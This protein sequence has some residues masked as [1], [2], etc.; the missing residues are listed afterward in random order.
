MKQMEKGG[1]V[2]YFFLS[3]FNVLTCFGSNLLFC[4]LHSFKKY[5]ISFCLFTFVW[6][7]SHRVVACLISFWLIQNNMLEC[8]I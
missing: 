4:W 1:K 2:T 7:K 5:I 8:V 3:L 6:G